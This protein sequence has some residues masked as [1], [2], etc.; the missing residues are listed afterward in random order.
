MRWGGV[1]QSGERLKI[2]IQT[3]KREQ[4]RRVARAGP[5][6][7]EQVTV[8]SDREEK[9]SGNEGRDRRYR[10]EGGR[11]VAGRKGEQEYPG[12]GDPM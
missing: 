11:D 7:G 9:R 12:I 2:E 5:P 6:T 3:Q 10:G 4:G 1:T 8:G